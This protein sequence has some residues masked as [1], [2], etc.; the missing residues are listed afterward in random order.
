MSFSLK[1]TDSSVCF[2][3]LKPTEEATVLENGLVNKHAYTVTDAEQVRLPWTVSS[4]SLSL[5][6]SVTPVH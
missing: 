3:P 4:L 6:Q 1:N 2:S 5:Y